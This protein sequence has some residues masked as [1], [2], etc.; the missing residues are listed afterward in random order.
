MDRPKPARPTGNHL[1]DRLPAAELGRLLS[2]AEWAR[3]APRDEVFGVGV[4]GQPVYFPTSAVFSLL[5]PLAG[6]HEVEVAVTDG[7]GMLGIPAVLGIEAQPLRALTQ[8]GG[9]CVRVSADRFRAVLREGEVMDA[10]VKRFLAVS[11]QTA[12]QNIACNQRHSVKERTCR[13]LLSVHDRAGTDEFEITQEVLAGMVG[14]SR[15]K[16]T[17]VAGGLQRAGVI[18]YQRGRVRVADRSGLEKHSCE[19]YRV[20]RKAYELLTL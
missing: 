4:V 9:D 2:G 14:A 1:L 17:V 20:L 11:W 3:F 6:G 5:L 8:V 13:W 19:C 16:V 15:Q 12:N 7:E 18:T 10:L